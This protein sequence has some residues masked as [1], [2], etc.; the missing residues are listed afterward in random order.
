MENIN[1]EKTNVRKILNQ[2]IKQKKCFD[3]DETKY[4][5][6]QCHE[7]WQWLGTK[8]VDKGRV[9][10]KQENIQKDMHLEAVALEKDCTHGRSRDPHLNGPRAAN[11]QRRKGRLWLD[12]NTEKKGDRGSKETA[13]K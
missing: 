4:E 12:G 10:K 6:K 11:E 5:R 8:N 13:K 2:E 1:I 7:W 9:K 3:Q